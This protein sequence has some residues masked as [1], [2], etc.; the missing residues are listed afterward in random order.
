MQITTQNT[1]IKNVNKWFVFILLIVAL[2]QSKAA[3]YYWVGGTGNW[4]DFAN[5]W[6][7]TS[8]GTVF[9]SLIP[10]LNDSV[11]F[12]VNSF[13]SSASKTVTVDLANV[14]C[15]NIDFTGALFGP[16]LMNSLAVINNY[17]SLT[18]APGMF[19]QCH[20]NMVAS[21][22]TK[23]I[24]TNGSPVAWVTFT[25]AATFSLTDDYNGDV[26]SI[27]NGILNT[28]NHPLH[29]Q[30]LQTMGGT[31][32]AGN[33][34]ITT[35][36]WQESIS[37]NPLVL[38]T[39]NASVI[40]SGVPN[41]DFTINNI[42]SPV[43]LDSVTVLNYNVFDLG[44]TCNYLNASGTITLN[45]NS[46]YLLQ[47]HKAIFQNNVIF[48][49]NFYVD[50]VLFNNPG[51]S[52]SM[53]NQDTIF[54]NNEWLTNAQPGFPISLNNGVVFKSSGQVCL[55][56][57]FIQNSLATGGAQ[58]FA[59]SNSSDLGGNSGWQFTSCNAS[60][61]VYY[62]V[63]GTGD[64][65]DYSHHWATT[66]GGATF[67]TSPPGPTDVVYF[68]NSSF[69]SNTDTVYVNSA[70][71]NIYCRDFKWQNL[72]STPTFYVQSNTTL[73]VYG[74]FLLHH[75]LNFSFLGKI[76][77]TG[78]NSNNHIDCDG[79]PISGPISI[80]FA[81]QVT[82]SANASWFLE[83]SFTANS[84][85]I[86]GGDIKTNNHNI[87]IYGKLDISPGFGNPI[88]V[89]LGTSEIL[90]G[91][92]FHVYDDS[93]LYPIRID[94]DSATIK[95][96]KN[97]M[98]GITTSILAAGSTTF[99]KYLTTVDDVFAEHTTSG[100]TLHIGKLTIL[101][102]MEISY[103]N[104]NIDTLFLNNPGGMISLQFSNPN[105]IAINS[106]LIVN[107]SPILPITFFSSSGDTYK[108][109]KTNGLI[110]LH[111]V[112][113]ENCVAY[114]G[115]Q[116]YAGNGCVDLGGNTGWTFA[117]C[118]NV[119]DVWPGDA[120]YDLSVNNVDVLNIGLAY[121]D[122]GAVRP[123]ASTAWLAQPATDWN[124]YFSSAV[125]HK[126]AD[127]DGNGSVDYND[128]TA[129]SQNYGLT[130]PARLAAPASTSSVNDPPLYL[131]VNPDSVNLS[132]TVYIETYYGTAQVPVDSVYG[133]AFSIN[134]DTALVDTSWIDVQFL[135]SWLGT[136]GSD[137]LTFA[138]SIPVNGRIDYALVRNDHNNASGYGGPL[139][140]TGIIIVDNVAGR[141]TMPI[142]I[143]NP[144]AITAYEYELAVNLGID[145]VSID[146]TALVGVQQ[147]VFSHF[148]LTPN[149][150]Q[151]FI[152][153]KN[154]GEASRLEIN[155]IH[156]QL[157][158][159]ENILSEKNK[160]IDIRH[161]SRGLYTVKIYNKEQ[162]MIGKLIKM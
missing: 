15:K 138:K 121:G 116:F 43:Q 68:G 71:S 53:P 65:S 152:I 97:I 22:G 39:S 18:L 150:A 37:T 157:V 109:K 52:I 63:G 102:N 42:S 148:D 66:N 8:G 112:Y 20:F 67:H 129:I 31:F 89:N 40:F 154:I 2:Q 70:L 92:F 85:Q 55:D 128:T 149:P 119:S 81:D 44:L 33:S 132:D 4:S 126:H 24:T 23:T 9:H 26:F 80:T 10:S 72:T 54:I 91:W 95:F 57:Y 30:Y 64:W 35:G 151:D 99:Y 90:M 130:H 5:H 139:C 41:G 75:N 56:Y 87:T 133:I 114:G 36:S 137:L 110:C 3:N 135:N 74:S 60:A 88:N 122:T 46:G 47:V 11:F 48:A 13:P 118:S 98:P 73:N 134:Y 86:Y 160:L 50:S 34:L 107:S 21:S 6:A 136:P 17:G 101:K 93:T 32:N 84:M 59:G 49:D 14:Y 7:T 104:F 117:S 158:I 153:L 140:R 142:T 124:G 25:G 146:T 125:N 96:D 100:D 141:L 28:N 159:N 155:D 162:V 29:V 27:Q 123:G 147:N 127:C 51:Y 103:S 113:L 82:F 111:D 83:S 58:F 105:E 62:W 79:V 16:Q 94:A 77:F 108:I 131:T 61:N 144:Y 120:N 19:F 69:V 45:S 12:D 78:T 38:N 1:A 76:N 156:G 161:L 106:E 143:S 115:A 145:S